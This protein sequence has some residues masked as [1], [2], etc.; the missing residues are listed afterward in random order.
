MSRRWSRIC[1]RR[2]LTGIWALMLPWGLVTMQAASSEAQ[3]VVLGTVTDG[4]WPLPGV[5]L[6]LMREDDAAAGRQ[7]RIATTDDSGHFR[8]DMLAPGMFSIAARR[9][10]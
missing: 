1:S 4:S 10:G 2:M 3:A 9:L 7:P 8:F 6:R 5:E